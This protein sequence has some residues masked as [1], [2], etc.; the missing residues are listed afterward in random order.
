MDDSLR[1]LY[2]QGIISA[3]ECMSRSDDKGTM[4]QYFQNKK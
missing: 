3:E 4:K 2:E 1:S